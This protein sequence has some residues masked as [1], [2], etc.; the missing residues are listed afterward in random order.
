MVF[1]AES[2]LSWIPVG[3]ATPNPS[4]NDTH[5][6]VAMKLFIRF[7][8]YLRLFNLEPAEG[9]TSKFRQMPDRNQ[10]N[11]AALYQAVPSFTSSVARP[12]Y[13]RCL[14]VA[15]ASPLAMPITSGVIGRLNR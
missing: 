5:R 13:S 7:L 10:L 8:S 6:H 14:N 9:I 3:C 2:A 12:V 4:H 11:Q 15:I 1:P